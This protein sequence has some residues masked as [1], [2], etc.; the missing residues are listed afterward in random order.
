M[1]SWYC[2]FR[3]NDII[4]S[5]SDPLLGVLVLLSLEL[6]S[7][8]AGTAFIPFTVAIIQAI[9]ESIFKNVYLI[10]KVFNSSQ[11]MIGTIMPDKRQ[12][13]LMVTYIFWDIIWAKTARGGVCRNFWFHAKTAGL[14]IRSFLRFHLWNYIERIS[15][16]YIQLNSCNLNSY[17]SKNRLN[18]RNSLVPSEFT[19]TPL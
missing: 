19:S 18:R 6:D 5:D 14:S 15:N 2:C 7:K 3:S 17:N 8:F 9:Q 11:P 16:P 13:S 1:L 10:N 4:R 12:E